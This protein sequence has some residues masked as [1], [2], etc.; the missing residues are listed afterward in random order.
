MPVCD[1]SGNLGYEVLIRLVSHRAARNGRADDIK[2]VARAN[3]ES[4]PLHRL[5]M[6]VP[7]RDE[8][9]CLRESQGNNFHF[10]LVERVQGA[11][12]VDFAMTVGK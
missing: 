4:V 6:A 2:S 9:V 7:C 8:F 10:I 5:V 12:A 1:H 3:R 11:K